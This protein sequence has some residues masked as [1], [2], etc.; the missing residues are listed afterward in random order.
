MSMFLHYYVGR[1]WQ[2]FFLR[3][4]QKYQKYNRRKTFSLTIVFRYVIKLQAQN[5]TLK[6][7]PI[8]RE[9]GGIRGVVR[10]YFSRD[11]E[12]VSSALGSK[13]IIV[14]YLFL[15]Q[16]KGQGISIFISRKRL[17]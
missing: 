15:G 3:L 14:I 1:R 11:E 9:P 5:K 12:K 8:T 13:F 7:K 16:E 17:C 2:P 6:A 10:V 4:Y